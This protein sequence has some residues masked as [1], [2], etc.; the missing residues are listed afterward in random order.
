MPTALPR[1]AVLAGLTALP[2]LARGAAAAPGPMRRAEAAAAALPQ[3]HCLAIAQ[4]GRI[5][6]VRAFRGPGPERPVNVKSVSKALVSALAGITIDRGHLRGIGQPVLPF[7]RDYLPPDPDPRLRE[8]TLADLLTMRSGLRDLSGEDYPEWA[9]S[10]NW[11]RKAL[12]Q[13]LVARPGTRMLYST[14]T[15]HMLGH[16]LARVTGM[17]LHALATAWLGRPLG[18]RLPEWTR[19]PQGNYL[20]GNDM[21]L[22]PLA[23]L[24]FGEMFRRG[25]R[26]HERVVP[27]SWVRA[28]WVPRAVSAE[29]GHDYGYGWYG[30]TAGGTRLHYARGYGGQL[31]AVAPALELVVAVTSDPD[32]PARLD[33]HLGALFALIEEVILPEAAGDG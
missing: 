1:R 31:I 16:V 19:D 11:L 14:A 28:S 7:L 22:S 26:W 10:E 4:H 32:S 18:I 6:S 9:T 30:W 12:A 27:E 5:R 2:A 8:L 33:G 3:L 13:P 25:G 21:R 15:Y 20:G 24:R 17:D 23:M 29:T